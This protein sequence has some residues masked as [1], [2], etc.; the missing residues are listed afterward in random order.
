MYVCIYAY[1]PYMS[2]RACVRACVRVFECVCTCVV[3]LCA[4]VWT[5]VK[6]ESDNMDT[7]CMCT[8]WCSIIIYLQDAYNASK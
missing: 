6:A 3:V 1:R 2:V 5:S 8:T 4:C 7:I